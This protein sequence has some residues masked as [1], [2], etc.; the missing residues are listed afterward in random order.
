LNTMMGRRETHLSVCAL[1]GHALGDLHDQH[2]CLLLPAAA[3]VDVV[4]A[5][6]DQAYGGR[7]IESDKLTRTTRCCRV[8]LMQPPPTPHLTGWET[9]LLTWG[10]GWCSRALLCW[11]V[12][13]Q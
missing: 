13:W 8:C 5:V 6:L 4:T 12:H 2:A 9:W 10:S 3:S 1:A 11:R 7:C